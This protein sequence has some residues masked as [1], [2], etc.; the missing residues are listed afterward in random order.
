MSNDVSTTVIEWPSV[1]ALECF[2]R[3]LDH[4]PNIEIVLGR[5]ACLHAQIKIFMYSLLHVHVHVQLELG[6]E[7]N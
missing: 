5:I 4:C 6:T 7:L 3:K 2:D 1:I